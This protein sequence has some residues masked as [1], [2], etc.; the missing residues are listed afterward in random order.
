V[1]IAKV[2]FKSKHS[3]HIE[4]LVEVVRGTRA[5]DARGKERRSD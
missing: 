1:T 5:D 3:R 2:I 4:N